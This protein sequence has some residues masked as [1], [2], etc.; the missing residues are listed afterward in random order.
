MHQ[1]WI[2][3][4]I[5][6]IKL[7]AQGRI[8]SWTSSLNTRLF[9]VGWPQDKAA[10]GK[11][12]VSTDWTAHNICRLMASLSVRLKW[13]RKKIQSNRKHTL[14][15]SQKASLQAQ[16]TSS[17]YSTVF[18]NSLD[19]NRTPV[20]AL[21]N[22]TRLNRTR[23]WI[24]NMTNSETDRQRDRRTFY[25]RQAGVPSCRRQH[26]ERPSAPRRICTVTRGCQAASQDFHLLLFLPGHP[27]TTYLFVI[28]IIVFFSDISCGPC[29][30]W[31]FRPR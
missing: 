7:Y 15:Q 11:H 9:H 26:V 13:S 22:P 1:A 14:F 6:R 21:P 17:M 5:D 31:H 23:G 30:N 2:V 12:R 27:D 28:I 19:R 8:S 24:P 3:S 20:I 10:Q 25:S 16:G 18:A 4:K 29:N